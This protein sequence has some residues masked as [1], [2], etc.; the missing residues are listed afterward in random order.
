M[1]SVKLQLRRSIR[2]AKRRPGEEKLNC[3]AADD[4]S[5][6]RFLNEIQTS[7]ESPG[8]WHGRN[9][10]LTAIRQKRDIAARQALKPPRIGITT[11]TKDGNIK[12][13]PYKVLAPNKHQPSPPK[14][15]NETKQCAKPSTLILKSPTPNA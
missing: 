9:S 4:E 12:K 15:R 10:A 6:E 14:G 8:P 2:T 3:G 11:E 5:E 1:K 7:A 13:S